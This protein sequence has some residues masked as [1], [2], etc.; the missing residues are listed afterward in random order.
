VGRL[1]RDQAA[2]FI[3]PASAT[4]GVGFFQERIGG[5]PIKVIDGENWD[6]IAHADLVLA[7]SGTVTVEAALLRTPMV[8]FYKVTA[9]S[10]LLGRMLVRIPFYSMVN[11]IAGRAVVPE[12]MQSN[13]TGPRLAAE[14]Q[15]LLRDDGARAQMRADLAEVASRLSPPSSPMACASGIIQDLMEGQFTHAS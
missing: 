5:A 10:W 3:L 6:S 9:A 8:T 11:I 14:A 4:A 12:L 2:S 7:A 15:R 13:L 1:Y